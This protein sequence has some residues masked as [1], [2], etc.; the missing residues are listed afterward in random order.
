L[1][2]LKNENNASFILLQ[3]IWNDWKNNPDFI[4]K[5]GEFYVELLYMINYAGILQGEYDYVMQVFNHAINQLIKEPVQ[6]ANFEVIKFLALNKIYNK[7]ARYDEV[8]KLNRLMKSHY[9]QWEP[10][11]NTDLNRTTNLS[12]G[13]GSFVLEQYDDALYYIKN[14]VSYFKDGT[15]Q[16][17]TAVANILLLLI[18]YC[19]NN[20][21][22]FDAQYRATYNYFNK[23]KKKQP[24]ETA[25]VQC[26]HRTF[27]MTDM[28]GKVAEYRKALL[29]FEK[30]KDNLIQQLNFS[31]FNYH[32][33]LTSRAE[34]IPY[35][36]YVE[37]KVK[38]ADIAVSFT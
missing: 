36:Q 33:W 26:L 19:I 9:R 15:R 30:N 21:R 34:R 28:A 16:E 7:T 22:L 12:L 8:D 24:F 13:I 6:R 29:V 10:A 2:Y 31:I 5:D 3:E 32:A 17:H 4:S 1:L 27:Y 25:L 37:R 14:A 23:R 35:R 20:P 38:K 18:C 11:L